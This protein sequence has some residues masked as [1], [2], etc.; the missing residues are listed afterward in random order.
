[1]EMTR[2][3]TGW[4]TVGYRIG[5]ECEKGKLMRRHIA[6]TLALIVFFYNPLLAT[7]CVKYLGF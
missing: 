4:P 1:M 2:R 5:Y 7:L 3:Y 6:V